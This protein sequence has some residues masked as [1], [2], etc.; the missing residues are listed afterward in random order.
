LLRQFLVEPLLVAAAG[1]ALGVLIALAGIEAL[2]RTSLGLPRVHEVA[3]DG[4]SLAFA[5]GAVALAALVSG[6]P[7]AWRRAR[8][9]PALDLAG[10]PARVAGPRHGLRDGLVVAEVALAVVLLACASLLVRSYRRLAAVDP[11][12]D[13]R[14]V[15]VAPIFLDMEAYGH[16]GKSRTYYATLVE[17]LSGLPGVVSVGGATALP[18]SPLGPDFARPVWPEARAS[19]EHLRRPAWVRMVTTGYFRTLGMRVVAGRG[20]DDRDSP[21]GARAVILS[22]GLARQLWPAGDA[23]GQRL[24]VDYSRAGTYPYDVVGVVNDVLFSGPRTEPRLEI[25]LPHAQ[26]PYLVLNVAVK[27]AHDPRYLAPA[28][29]Q[30]LHELDP[31]KPAHALQTLDDL[32]GATYSRDRQATVVLA[33]F[34]AATVLLALLGL[35]GV[36]S[37]LVRERRREIG[38]RMAIGA[39]RARLLSWV[40]GEGLRLVLIGVL[41]GAALAAA[42]TRFVGG[43]LYGVSPHDPVAAL[44]V[45]ALPFLGLAVSLVPAWRA[46]R[47]DAAEVLRAG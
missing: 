11:G 5:F 8:A 16:G 32:L 9:H 7:A 2:K 47:V 14:G 43:L 13:P 40:A 4:G 10:T 21:D 22:E 24:V 37:H 46:T 39:G 27:T 26:R 6:L 45:L 28:V 3:L 36:L 34:A 30:V 35:H 23:V 19:E 20:F 12:F 38:I 18:A 29:R 15:L 17:R 1:G 41:L 44:A 42:S 25:Y 33:A 31:A